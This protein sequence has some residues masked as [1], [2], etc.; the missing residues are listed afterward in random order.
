MR[1]QRLGRSRIV[2]RACA[3]PSLANSGPETTLAMRACCE[4]FANWE[5]RLAFQRSLECT[6]ILPGASRIFQKFCMAYRN[7]IASLATIHVCKRR[8]GFCQAI[9]SRVVHASSGSV[10]VKK[11]SIR[12]ILVPTDFSKTSIQVIEPAKWLAGRFVAAI[13]LVHVY[14]SG[15]PASLVVPAPPFSL[16]PY[17]QEAKERVTMAFIG[18]LYS[19]VKCGKARCAECKNS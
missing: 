4:Q 8:A 7:R 5:I 13:H 19:R 10:T 12:N 3:H 1:T 16:T 14:E 2:P 17:E 11:L 9:P 6:K 18:P 15:Y